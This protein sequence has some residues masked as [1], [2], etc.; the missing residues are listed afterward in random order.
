MNEV[1]ITG[2]RDAET[3]R[4]IGLCVSVSLRLVIIVLACSTSAVAQE[5]TVEQL[6]ATALERSPEIRAARTA[7]T[8]AGGQ[9]TQAGL[10]PNPTLSGA[11]ADD[12]RAA[13]DA[14]RGQ[15]PLDLFRRE[16]RVGTA[17]AVEATTLGVQIA[18][19]CSPPPF[20]RRR[21]ACWLLAGTSR[22]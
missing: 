21:D 6:V 16:A 2:R 14:P 19:A 4:N 7:I 22:S 15:W 1:M 18:S 11:D 17:H 12:R 8:A 10:R 20:D 3:Q 13:P 9:L 5:G